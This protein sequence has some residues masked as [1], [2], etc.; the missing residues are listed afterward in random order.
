MKNKVITKERLIL[1]LIVIFMISYKINTVYRSRYFNTKDDTGIFWTESALQQRTAKIVAVNGRLAVSDKNAQYPEGLE[2]RDRLTTTM[3][4]IAGYIYRLF[5]PGQ[6][7][8]HFFLII[9]ISI[10]SSLS[11]IP[12]YLS[13][14]LVTK[15]KTSGLFACIIYALTPAV[16]ITVTAPAF[17][18]QDFALPLIFTH[19]YFF[20][21]A[22][23]SDDAA[24]YS[25]AVLSGAFLLTALSSWHLTQFYYT[26]FVLFMGMII[27]CEPE[28][29]T[30][31]FYII[32]GIGLI[33]GFLIP[34][35]RTA[36]FLFSLS[37]LLSYCIAIATLL[38]VKKYLVKR[39]LL[40]FLC[41]ITII[42]T[43]IIATKK[44]PE[45][46][47]VYGLML[48]KIKYLGRRPAD[49]SS[50]TWETL[51]MWV[52]P[53]TSPSAKEIYLFIGTLTIIG[54]GG[55]IINIK[56]FLK[57]TSKIIDSFLLLFSVA[58]IPLYLLIIRLD[59]FLVWF[60][61]LQTAYISRTLKKSMRWIL[62]LGIVINGLLLFNQPAKILGPKHNY[63]LGLIRYIRIFTPQNSV[64]LTSF[65]YG[66][67]ILTYAD[68]KIILHPKFEAK[69][70]TDKVKLFEHNLFKSEKD[71][72]DYCN[73][74]NA[75][76]FVYHTDMLMAQGTESIRYR[77]HNSIVSKDCVAYKFHFRPETLSHFTLIYSNPHYRIYQISQK[78]ESA[79]DI[80]IEYFRI[81]DER[82]ISLK[83]LNVH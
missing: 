43:I 74:Y 33:G 67:S 56:K 70:M 25:Y 31:P 82:I 23:K 41:I 1:A 36:G 49:P 19:L 55:I 60:L 80:P 61:A 83:D 66:P 81:Y 5:I 50:L 39:A 77:T 18:L 17:E 24:K 54:I 30:R 64:V 20:I 28:T 68:R 59:V 45:Y 44:I 72:Y 7:P 79:P 3:E 35:L 32:T 73:D 58:F 78:G 6:L 65:A 52:S 46:R 27:F 13:S 21:R 34:V 48:D 38:P 63:L 15:N 2:Y 47:Y 42:I 29:D 57:K 69:N 4:I 10:W 22:M 11:I 75:D 71:F 53:F 26:M 51:V 62:V 8:F 9:F 40:I 37:M 76:I 14:C 12:L 16:Y